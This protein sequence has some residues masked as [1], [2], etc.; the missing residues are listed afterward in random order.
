V[1]GVGWSCGRKEVQWLLDD[2]VRWLDYLE[3]SCAVPALRGEWCL[4]GLHKCR[5]FQHHDVTL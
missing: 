5:V 4:L 2:L 3:D 1:G